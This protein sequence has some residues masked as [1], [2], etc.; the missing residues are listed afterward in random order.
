MEH[1]QEAGVFITLQE[2]SA[3]FPR[4]KRA[5]HTMNSAERHVLIK[6]ERTLYEY[7]SVS[8]AEE[9]IQVIGSLGKGDGR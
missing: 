4:L 2:L 3:L 9:L 5:E 1:P 8:E 7:L 6:L